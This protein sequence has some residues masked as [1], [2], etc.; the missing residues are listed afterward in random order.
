M[1]RLLLLRHAKAVAGSPKL[2]DHD[3]PLNDRGHSDA[4]RVGAAMQHK[5]YVPGIVLCSTAKRTVETCRHVVAEFDAAPTVEFRDDLYLAPAKIIANAVRAIDVAADVALVIGHNPGLEECAKMLAR[6]PRSDSERKRLDAL[7]IKFPTA[8]LAV[9]DFDVDAWSGIG[10]GE[11]AL[12]DFLRP[13]DI[14]DA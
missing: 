5:L 1:K 11:G 4:P 13:R 12:T 14:T 8:A 6:K 2:G 7:A 10:S 9:I 3:R